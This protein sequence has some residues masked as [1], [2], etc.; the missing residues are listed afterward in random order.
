MVQK[1]KGRLVVGSLQAAQGGVQDNKMNE[2][3]VTAEAGNVLLRLV[4]PP[5]GS[6]SIYLAND[7]G[8]GDVFALNTD[9]DGVLELYSKTPPDGTWRLVAKIGGG[10][11]IDAG[12][13]AVVLAITALPATSAVD[14]TLVR[15]NEAI[16]AERLVTLPAT[17]ARVGMRI[18]VIRT[19]AATG[20]NVVDVGG[21]KDL[22]P[23]EWA[24]VF[25]TG[26]AWI[27]SGFGSL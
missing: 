6:K 7:D 24:E 1:I 10:K 20:E 23:G 17:E 8:S 19:A 4:A 18:K 13:A 9:N 27:L 21:L 11:F 3:R 15:Y 22:D 26:S 16:A 2:F 25:Y 12:D 14:G 5:T